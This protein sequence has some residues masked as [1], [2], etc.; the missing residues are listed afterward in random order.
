LNFHAFPKQ[1]I[2]DY[3]PNLRYTLDL[4]EEK[5]SVSAGQEA[6]EVRHQI[7]VERREIEE[8]VGM[9]EGFLSYESTARIGSF[10]SIFSSQERSSSDSDDHSNSWVW[11]AIANEDQ[12]C[13]NTLDSFFSNESDG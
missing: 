4:L 5:L 6:E 2:R 13:Q 11:K 8:K 12:I 9:I 7:E 10:R 3:L 1:D